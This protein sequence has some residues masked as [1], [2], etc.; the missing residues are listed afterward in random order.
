MSLLNYFSRKLRTAP[1]TSYIE[2]VAY[3]INSGYLVAPKADV[4]KNELGVEVVF[5]RTGVGEYLIEAPGVFNEYKKVV[6]I[7]NSQKGSPIVSNVFWNDKD[8]LGVYIWNL[9]G[10]LVDNFFVGNLVIRVYL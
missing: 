4:M 3:V 8:S 9:G 5:K 1:S 10:Q 7:F 2:Y 6:P